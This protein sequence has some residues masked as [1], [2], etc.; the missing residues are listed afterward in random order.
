MPSAPEG[1]VVVTWS[2][3]PAHYIALC[4]RCHARLDLEKGSRA[5]IAAGSRA[6]RAANRTRRT[7]T[8]FNL[9]AALMAEP[10]ARHYGSALRWSDG[11]KS[12]SLYAIL[13]RMLGEGWLVDGWEDAAAARTEGR[14]PRRYYTVT[15]A[16]RTAMT[17]LLRAASRARKDQGRETVEETPGERS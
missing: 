2:D 14:P 5:N 8:F 16:G 6:H 7:E 9:A 17:E 3:D 12:G 4:Y 15:E 13:R 10:G 1:T 11:V